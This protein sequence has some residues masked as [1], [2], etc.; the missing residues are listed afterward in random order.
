MPGA[1][2]RYAGH[3]YWSEVSSAQYFILIAALKSSDDGLRKLLCIFQELSQ[4]DIG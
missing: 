1:S 2:E 4:P 3:F